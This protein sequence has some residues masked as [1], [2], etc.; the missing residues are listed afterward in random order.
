MRALILVLSAAVVGLAVMILV[1]DSSQAGVPA[2]PTQRFWPSAM[3]FNAEPGEEA[4]YR[5][6][7]GNRISFRV[8]QTIRPPGRPEDRLLIRRR[9]LDRTGQLMGPDADVA[10]EHSVTR[11]GWFP[12][13]APEEASGY[14]RVWIWQRIRESSLTWH[15]RERKCWRVDF[16]DP[17]LPE[18]ADGVQAWY[19][20]DAPVFGIIAW[21]RQD[22]TWT[23]TSW[24]PEA[25]KPD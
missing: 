18:G 22:H 23:L 11:H 25:W 16:I 24:R 5:D 20:E 4:E 1:R 8:E 14:D 21:S 2:K 6:E 7:E 9:L 15:G 12:L 19:L 3:L 10:Y 17:A 13:M